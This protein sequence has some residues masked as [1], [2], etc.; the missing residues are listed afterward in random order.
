[1]AAK[2]GAAARTGSARTPLPFAA[3]LF[4]LS[5]VGALV[6][7]TTWLR[8]FRDLLGATA[9][10]ASAT[11]VAFFT[12]QA[13]GALAGSRLARRP[14]PLRIYGVLEVAAACGALATPLLLD[15]LRAVLDP[16]T[17]TLRETPG[18]LHAARYGAALIA[19]LPPA[20]AFGASFPVLAAAS[21]GEARALGSRGALLYGA[22]TAGAALG[23]ALATFVLPEILGV[24]GTHGV[25]VGLL[26]LAGGS[27]LLLAGTSRA[28]TGEEAP[29][30][31]DAAP[32][33]PPGAAERAL[34][35]L[36]A[37]SGFGVLATQVLLTQAFARVLNQS[38]FAFGAVLVANL[39]ALALG[40]LGI[41]AFRR[42]R[43][44]Q[45]VGL[46]GWLLAI[47]AIAW[48]AFP[49]LFVAGTDGLAYLGSGAPWPGYLGEVFRCVAF[50]AGPA[51]LLAAGVWPALLGLAGAA[52]GDAARG[53][54]RAGRLLVWNTGGA[55]AGAVLAPYLFLP[56][57]GLWGAFALVAALYG[58]GAITSPS[59]DR[60]ARLTRDVALGLGWM[61]VV[62][63]GHP[64]E[65]PPLRVA[66]GDRLLSAEPGAAGLVAVLEG[67]RGRWI[68]T[69]NHYALGGSADT[70]HQ[71]RQG[72]LPLLL[73]G[74]AKRVAFLGSA[75]GSSA[76]AALAHPVDEVVLVEIVPGVA[77]AARRFFAP[78]NRGVYDDPRTRVVVDDARNFLRTSGGGFDVIVGDL[79][80]PWRAGTGALYA[81]EHFRVAR[82]RLAPGG[83]FCQWLPLYQLDAEEL[84]TVT[85]TFL[86]VFPDA[87]VFRGDF[88]GRH[89][90]LALVGRAGGDPLDVARTARAAAALASAG[91]SDRWM[92][93]PVGPWAFYLGPAAPGVRDG[94]VN[95]DDRP[96][97]EFHA[98]RTHVGGDAGKLA[99]ITGP[100]FVAL[101]QRWIGAG[102]G[103]S[104]VTG[105]GEP[106]RRAAHGGHAL[107]TASALYSAGQIGPAGEALAV[108]SALLPR[109]LFAEAA[110]DPSVSEVW[111]TSEP[112]DGAVNEERR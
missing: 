26:A 56:A 77:D 61:L 53:G 39:A 36:A 63:R 66:E 82:Q 20:F 5:G 25:G 73:H 98:A 89:P 24:S 57:A 60:R 23:A 3:A 28:S 102:A 69:D 13:L 9:P 99:P 55:I 103:P 7:E 97:I 15:A 92:T 108:A 22:N 33:A 96:V 54:E 80:V 75:T 72:H 68:Q 84:A 104:P 90:I 48:A 111:H 76:G 105:F 52:G 40:A 106:E 10:A 30:E 47:A 107:Q 4:L 87:L 49:A 8:W 71:E 94:P 29:A 112:G 1:V 2:R 6:V 45:A 79:F 59:G 12:G 101:A 46:P 43:P 32:E 70:V 14:G 44:G 21:L 100:A 51:L 65:L 27:A 18:L 42:F 67:P 35:F 110:E 16:A 62:S 78:F 41:G 74:A 83:I 50:T 88:Y 85:R 81:E 38:S 58:L 95:S 93:D 31:R 11:L 37:L 34:P 19:T 64:L 17:E 86:R 109:R 91:V